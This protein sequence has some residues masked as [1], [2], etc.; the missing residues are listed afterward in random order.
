MGNCLSRQHEIEVIW[1][2]PEFA[3]LVPGSEYL[4]EHALQ[5]TKSDSTHKIISTYKVQNPTYKVSSPLQCSDGN[6]KKTCGLQYGISEIFHQIVVEQQNIKASKAHIRPKTFD[7]PE[8]KRLYGHMLDD[9]RFDSEEEQ[10]I[11]RKSLS[12][13]NSNYPEI[14]NGKEKSMFYSPASFNFDSRIKD[15]ESCV[16]DALDEM[17]VSFQTKH[18]LTSKEAA[19][20]KKIQDHLRKLRPQLAEQEFVDELAC[21]FYQQRGILIHSLKLDEHLKVLTNRAREYRRQNKNIE[22]A[23]IDFEKKLT[24]ELNISEQVLI[25]T[26]D[27]VV[28]HLIANNKVNDGKGI[29]GRLIRTSIDA[30]LKGNDRKCTM[31]LFK[32]GHDYSMDDVKAGIKLGKFEQNVG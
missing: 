18:N 31:K 5:E 15:N 21:F 30:V 14:L 12:G 13:M 9:I 19:N 28:D 16:P 23:F 17:Q 20:L 4:S 24:E 3:D 22:F 26:T 2:E 11:F 32:P 7:D 29:N 6:C 10:K 27:K 25:D 1:P 8:D